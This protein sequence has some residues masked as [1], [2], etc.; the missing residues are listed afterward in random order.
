MSWVVKMSC[1]PRGFVTGSWKS[2]TKPGR[3]LR[4]Q[5]CIDLIE[6]QDLDHASQGVEHWADE[7]RTMSEYQPTL[8]R[9]RTARLDSPAL[10]MSRTWRRCLFILDD[11]HIIDAQV[12]E[13][14]QCQSRVALGSRR[15]LVVIIEQC[16]LLGYSR[17]LEESLGPR[18]PT[19][20]EVA[21]EHP[22]SLRPDTPDSYRGQMPDQRLDLRVNRPR[23]RRQGEGGWREQ[24]PCTGESP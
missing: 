2:S 22:H 23:R 6:K 15:E 1:A 21:P 16:C 19:G 9:G 24:F 13:P 12:R 20:H 3:Q 14:Q 7:R 17:I 4:V 10:W 11:L 18:Q 5:A 8:H